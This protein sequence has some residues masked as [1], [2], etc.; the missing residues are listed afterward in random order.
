MYIYSLGI[1]AV[2]YGI[3]VVV[4]FVTNVIVVVFLNDDVV[5]IT[6]W[7]LWQNYLQKVDTLNDK[8]VTYKNWTISLKNKLCYEKHV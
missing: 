4:V 7:N 8:G 2:I 5:V 1:G 6:G 3:A